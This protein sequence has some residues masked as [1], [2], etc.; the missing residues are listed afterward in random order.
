MTEFS[1]AVPEDTALRLSRHLSDYSLERKYLVLADLHGDLPD[2][3][4]VSPEPAVDECPKCG[5]H[6]FGAESDTQFCRRCGAHWPYNEPKRAWYP[7]G[8][9]GVVGDD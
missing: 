7:H 4:M 8:S 9:V 3:W 6:H 5:S 2:S 1:Y